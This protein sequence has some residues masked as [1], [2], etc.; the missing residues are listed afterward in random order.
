L[1]RFVTSLRSLSRLTLTNLCPPLAPSLTPFRERSLS[2]PSATPPRLSH[3][4]H[5]NCKRL[6]ARRTGT[7]CMCCSALRRRRR[8]W[9]T[10]FGCLFPASPLTTRSTPQRSRPRP[11]VS[12]LQATS[13][14]QPCLHLCSSRKYSQ[15]TWKPACA[16]LALNRRA[17]RTQP[18]SGVGRLHPQSGSALSPRL[19]SSPARDDGQYETYADG[20][21]TPRQVQ[22]GISQSVSEAIGRRRSGMGGRIRTKPRRF[23]TY[24]DTESHM[25]FE[26]EGVEST[27]R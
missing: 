3:P 13:A 5:P 6:H 27:R 14:A 10:L 18:R 19:S 24:E 4:C 21:P 2:P 12:R 16:R 11:A 25:N 23:S 17:K 20:A 8:R 1:R 26:Q 22:R 7:P 15:A 9:R